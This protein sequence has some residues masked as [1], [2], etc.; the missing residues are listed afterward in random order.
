M[1]AF[2]LEKYSQQNKSLLNTIKMKCNELGIDK[3][4]LEDLEGKDANVKIV[5]I[6]QFSAG[7]SSII[8]MLTGEDVAIGAKITTQKS[9]TYTWNGIDII[10]TPGIH[11]ELRFDHDAITYKQI[12]K[13]ALLVYVISNEGFSQHIGENFRKLAIDQKRADHMVLVVNKMDRAP[14]GNVPEQQSIIEQDLQKVTSPYKPSDLYL[15][16]L[17]TNS[18]FESLTEKDLDL[19]EELL[20]ASGYENFI[21]NLNLFVKEH[22]LIG[23]LIKPL[24]H[25]REFLETSISANNVMEDKDIADLEKTIRE[26]RKILMDGKE[27]CQRA[28]RDIVR[29]CREEIKSKGRLGA[30]E[31]LNASE[32]SEADNKMAEVNNEIENCITKCQDDVDAK[33]KESLVALGEEIKDYDNSYFVKS[34]SVNI[35][36]R[37]A[38]T[39]INSR[40]IIVKA[41]GM[42]AQRAKEAENP[43]LEAVAKPGVAALAAGKAADAAVAAVFPDLAVGAQAVG[44]I[45]GWVTKLFTPEPTVWEKG[46]AFLGRNAGKIVGV[47]A[48]GYALWAEV[49]NNEE[50][51]KQEQERQKLKSE[52]AKKYSDLSDDF[53]SKIITEAN[54]LIDAN[55]TPA[56][57][58]QNDE[59]EKISQARIDGERLNKELGKLLKEVNRKIDE[60]K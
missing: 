37:V 22:E 38:D 59:L 34:V 53:Q 12:N 52:L 15:S 45:G 25:A 46:A 36:E 29:T 35:R 13:A 48:L 60:L 11:T 28:V 30:E 1:R 40:G 50:Q 5:F 55:I 51:Q 21:D 8:K 17:D 14:M 18:Y 56:I 58:S 7:K 32:Q 49:K 54:K 24:Y 47:A 41:M 44:G 4:L 10:D 23:T 6:G 20:Q 16:F 57:N 26:R 19:K 33:I 31:A 3:E 27:K 42:A 39:P 2:N 43:A 9:T